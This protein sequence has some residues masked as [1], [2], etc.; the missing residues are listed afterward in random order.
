MIRN[1][2]AMLYLPQEHRFAIDEDN[3][4]MVKFMMP[5]DKDYQTVVLHLKECID[6]YPDLRRKYHHQARNT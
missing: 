2:S 1:I 5:T 4:N 6:K 3:I